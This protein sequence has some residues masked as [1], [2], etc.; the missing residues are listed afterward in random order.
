[1]RNPYSAEAQVRNHLRPQHAGDI[2]SGGDAATGSDLFRDAAPADDIAA[3]EN[4]GRE[5]G[6]GEVGGRRQP[7]VACRRLRRH[8]RF[9][10]ASD[11]CTLMTRSHNAAMKAKI[12]YRILLTNRIEIQA[13]F[14]YSLMT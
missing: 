8:H 13:A 6:A 9:S 7:I 11:G 12:H 5:S 10:K 1:M 2:R 3:F 4:Q 14:L